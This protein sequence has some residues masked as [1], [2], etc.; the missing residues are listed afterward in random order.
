MYKM[1]VNGTY[2][3]TLDIADINEMDMDGEVWELTKLEDTDG[4]DGKCLKGDVTF[5]RDY[6]YNYN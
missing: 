6:E 2:V 4:W 5:I 3:N 1:Y